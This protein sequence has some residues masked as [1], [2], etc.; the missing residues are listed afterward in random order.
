M[1]TVM[2]ETAVVQEAF[3]RVSALVADHRADLD[4]AVHLMAAHA[5][6]GGG[7]PRFAGELARH[8]AT[9]QASLE[10]ALHEIHRL[11]VRHGMIPPGMPTV[12]TSVM[13][14]TSVP[15]SFRGVD[16]TA[17]RGLIGSLDRAA[18]RLCD[19]SVRLHAELN[20]LGLPTAAGWDLANSAEWARRQARD[21]R[22]RLAW[23]E[24]AEPD[25]LT[26]WTDGVVPS[27]VIGFGLFES[28]AP[29]P[30]RAAT[31]LRQIADGDPAAVAAMLALQERG[32]DPGLAAR[33]QTW[34][35]NLPR[36]LRD[37][38]AVAVPEAIG[39][40]NGVPVAVR[41]QANRLILARERDRLQAA[42]SVLT[43]A[44]AVMG[45]P[46]LV[47]QLDSVLKELKKIE[48][49]ERNLALGDAPGYPPTFLLSFSLDG[50]G[51][52]IFSWGDP[53]TAD[54][55]VT[56]VPG[57]GTTL[58]SFDGDIERARLLWRQSQA[59]AGGKQVASIAWLGYE[60]PQLDSGLVLPSRS[61]AMEGAADRGAGALAAFADGLRATHQP[62]ESAR[63]VILGH[64]YGSLVAGKA[65]VLRPGRLADDLIFVGSPGVG[66]EHATD[67]GLRPGH[68]WVGEAGNDV[69]AYLG[70]FAA[71]PGDAGFGAQ[72]FPVAR[73]V[74]NEAHS[75]YW[76]ADS[77][78]L[79]NMAEITNGRYT[80]L[81]TP[82]RHWQPELLMPELAPELALK[83][84]KWSE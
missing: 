37:Q 39:A 73:D 29:D 25:P 7:A 43:E 41:D 69:V 31:L 21:L 84:K 51:R 79:R 82:Q 24:R 50:I 52:T 14:M 72:R 1:L 55:T 53:D 66:V 10:T 45:Q 46:V 64:S 11:V 62:A 20:V 40:L 8:R 81:E 9:L 80:R 71:N 34:W 54:T 17:M 26:P 35:R 28:F 12:R 3:R 22:G 27:G 63:N 83:L 19:L 13:S 16:V 59:T 47:L 5:W 75:S 15:G 44:L 42:A 65:A 32:D 33:V 4:P 78:S 77:V 68:V 6:V 57:M 18:D 23:I 61:V 58:E 70:R 67:L 56:Y 49:V 76:H 48:M 60:A 74:I 38:L 30:G 2:A 36:G